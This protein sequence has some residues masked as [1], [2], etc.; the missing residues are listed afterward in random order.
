MDFIEGLPNSKGYNAILVV[1]DRLTKYSHFIAM[2]H[3]FTAVSVAVTFVK[4]IVRLHGFPRTIV[5]DRDKVFM[6]SFW[7]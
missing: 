1:L 5:S 4:E 7:C 2:K 3:P 6:S